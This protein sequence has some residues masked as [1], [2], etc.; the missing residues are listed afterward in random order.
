MEV[1]RSKAEVLL[2]GEAGVGNRWPVT[3]A[4]TGHTARPT[5]S[6]CHLRLAV[7]DLEI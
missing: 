5:F 3:S 7:L 2:L 1:G 4:G 6:S